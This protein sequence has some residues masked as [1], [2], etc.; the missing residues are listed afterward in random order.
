MCRLRD[1]VDRGALIELSPSWRRSNNAPVKVIGRLSCNDGFAIAGAFREKSETVSD[2]D[3]VE[4]AKTKS[5]A[6]LM[7]IAGRVRIDEPVTDVRSTAAAR[8]SCSRSP[9]TRARGFPR[10][11]SSSSINVAAMDKTLAATVAKRKDVPDEL[12]PFI[13]IA[14]G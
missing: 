11:A 12:R 4:V 2:S 13:D 3:L 10:W 7:A 1:N 9:A 14:L 5:Q 8:R 6:H